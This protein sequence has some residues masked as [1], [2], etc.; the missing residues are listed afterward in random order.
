MDINICAAVAE[1]KSVG[2]AQDSPRVIGGAKM[3]M[4]FMSQLVLAP[5]ERETPVHLPLLDLCSPDGLYLLSEGDELA[6]S[7]R[8]SNGAASLFDD[9]LAYFDFM[10]ALLCLDSPGPA[11]ASVRLWCTIAVT[12]VHWVPCTYVSTLGCAAAA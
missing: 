8:L 5:L 4:D 9:L 2:P 12:A 7:S 3:R 1:H 6:V 10:S 11:I